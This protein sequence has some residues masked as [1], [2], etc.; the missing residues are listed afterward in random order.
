MI[1][2]CYWCYIVTKFHF[3]EKNRGH[4]CPL[5]YSKYL[6]FHSPA[7]SLYS[8]YTNIHFLGASF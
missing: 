7:Q 1:F 6:I 3:L 5:T 4:F 8:R 2:L